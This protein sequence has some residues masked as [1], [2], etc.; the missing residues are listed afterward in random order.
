[1]LEI[2]D[3][4]TYEWQRE[5]TSGDIPFMGKSLYHILVDDTLFLFGGVSRS[6][7]NQLYKL[8]LLNYQWEKVSPSSISSIPSPMCEGGSVRHGTS[9]FVYGGKGNPL[10]HSNSSHG[11]TFKSNLNFGYLC[12]DG[13]HNALYEYNFVDSKL[14]CYSAKTQRTLWDHAAIFLL[15][16]AL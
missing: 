2:L 11:A 14:L 10:P 1:M 8:S 5:K 15:Q 4:C 16:F 13:W 6:Y 9:M 12:D 7:H 3:L